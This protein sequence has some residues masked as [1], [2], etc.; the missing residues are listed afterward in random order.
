MKATSVTPSI[1]LWLPNIFEFK[2]GIQVYSAFF[3]QA[4]QM[5]FPQWQYDVFIKHDRQVD[6]SFPG[7][8]STQFHFSGDWCL[9]LRTPAFA[10]QIL[11]YGLLKQPDLI[12]AT[13]L[14]FTLAAYWLKRLT[15]VPYWTVAHGVEAWNIERPDLQR[16]LHSADRILAVSGYTRDRLLKEQNLN[17][18]KVS[19]LPNTFDGQ[20]FQ[21][22][23]KPQRLLNRYNLSAD[24]LIILTV[25]RLDSS[26]QYKGYD[27]IIQALGKIRSFIP[28]VHY[29][30]VGEGNDRYRIE[31]LVKCLEMQSYV[32]LA[33]FVPDAELVDYY[34]L[35]DVFA[36]PSLGEGFGIVYLEALACGKPVLGGDR[37]GAVDALCHGELGVLVNPNNVD[38]IAEKLIDI[39]K[40]V[41]GNE[42]FDRPQR[43]REKV[44]SVYGFASYQEKLHQ[45]FNTA[46]FPQSC[47]QQ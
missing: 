7:I 41:S 5:A 20:R 11:S 15:G 29:I 10:L 12:I 40:K 36:M 32:T 17:P 34:N 35:C 33:G 18:T 44:M 14:N 3:L 37:D 27:R 39:L 8:N 16:A 1:H 4:L 43:L 13:H 46:N 2:G 21:I 42:F 25:A 38:E 24:C 26:E 6:P 9:P 19:I 30:L 28:N 31:G 47:S 22:S 45:I 23:P